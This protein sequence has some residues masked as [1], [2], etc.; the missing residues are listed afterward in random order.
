MCIMRVYNSK[1]K[2][3]ERKGKKSRSIS[4]EADNNKVAV[5]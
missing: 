3:K 5:V 1:E 4:K 2:G